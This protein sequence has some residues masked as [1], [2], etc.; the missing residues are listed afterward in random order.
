MKVINNLLKHFL[1][2]FGNYLV[3]LKPT[4]MNY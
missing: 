3:L 2:D 4:I 1:S